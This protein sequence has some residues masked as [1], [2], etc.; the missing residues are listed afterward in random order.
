MILFLKNLRRP[1][2][3][4]QSLD[5]LMSVTVP[6]IRSHYKKALPAGSIDIMEIL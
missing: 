2:G 6:S 5:S 4:C 1:Q 3:S